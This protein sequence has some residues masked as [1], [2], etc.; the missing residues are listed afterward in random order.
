MT[1]KFKLTD[2]IFLAAAALLFALRI[3]VGRIAGVFIFAASPHDDVL[4]FQYADLAAH[5]A[6]NLPENFLLIKDMGFPVFLKI[7]ELIGVQYVDAISFLWLLAAALMTWLFVLVT[8][9]KDRRIWLAVFA[10]V[11]FTPVA[12]T[13]IG[14]RI[15]RQG[16]LSPMYF[17]TLEM[18]AILFV[19]CWKEIKIS[20][21][22]LA[23]F[24]AI[25]GGVFTLTFYV[26]EDGVWLLICLA[27]TV[28]LC[29]VR[30]IFS[31]DDLH[32]KFLRA[33]AIILPLAVFAAGTVFYKSIN[34]KFFGVYEINARTEGELGRV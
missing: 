4:M 7:V 15:Y 21:K 16:F 6:K 3:W 25:F 12:F 19:C 14:R 22:R 28:L 11:L 27:A 10:F 5:F 20:V 23:V 29:F 18:M 2:G 8:D 32:T 33:G 24:S 30:N 31:A 1:E 17:L 26:K 9:V 34:E 13:A